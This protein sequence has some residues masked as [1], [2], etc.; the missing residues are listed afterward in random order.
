MFY[1]LRT[2]N[3]NNNTFI[4]RIIIVFNYFNL[5]KHYF[6]LI[7]FAN[8]RTYKMPLEIHYFLS[9]IIIKKNF[10]PIL[11]SIHVLVMRGLLPKYFCMSCVPIS[12]RIVSYNMV[13]KLL[14][15][16]GYIFKCYLT[17]YIV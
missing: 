10:N 9:I 12:H 7:A 8:N 1:I 17:I 6:I 5:F 13:L 3:Y 15:T 2:I 11:V 14:K 4:V 16:N